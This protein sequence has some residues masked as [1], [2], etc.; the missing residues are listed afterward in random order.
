[1]VSCGR[2]PTVYD[3]FKPDDA[4]AAFA[5]TATLIDEAMVKGLEESFVAASTE[6]TE[7]PES[8]EPAESAESAEST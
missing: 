3:V 6:P 1:M 2:L 7:T 5:G 8:A 4:D